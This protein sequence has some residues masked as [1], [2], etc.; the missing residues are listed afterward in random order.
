MNA[1]TQL[2]FGFWLTITLIFGG[3]MLSYFAP[4]PAL[5]PEEVR[6]IFKN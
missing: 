1:I 6:Y 4:G 5:T 3:M 2:K